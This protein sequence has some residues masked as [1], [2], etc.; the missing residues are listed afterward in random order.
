MRQRPYY[1]NLLQ[2]RLPVGGWVSILHRASGA[3]LSLLV[4][5]LLYGL[6]LSLRSAEDFARVQAWL[7]GGLGWLLALLVSWALL[8]HFLAGLRHLGFDF[9]WGEDRLRARQTAWLALG[10][11]LALTAL[12]AVAGR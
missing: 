2:I 10:L 4:P 1:L 11:A 3:L 12:I 5:A 7:G 6:M 8:H 9:G